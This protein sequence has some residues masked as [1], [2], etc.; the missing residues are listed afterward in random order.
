MCKSI[1]SRESTDRRRHKGRAFIGRSAR[2]CGGTGLCD[3]HSG[4]SE[5]AS[6]LEGGRAVGKPWKCGE[7]GK[8]FRVPSE[9]ETHRRGHTGERPFSCPESGKA[10]IG[11]SK[12]LRHRRVHT[13]D[14][15]YPCPECGKAL[16]PAVPPADAP[17]PPH[18]RERPLTCPGGGKAFNRSPTLRTHRRLPNVIARS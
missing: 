14:R 9:L 15:P 11:S 4:T 7:C 18:T 8:G 17:A 10:F 1:R 3:A 6:N 2:L 16:H 13:G 12:L 5:G